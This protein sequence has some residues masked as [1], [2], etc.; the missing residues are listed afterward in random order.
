[1][2]RKREKGKK[3]LPSPPKKERKQYDDF[4]VVLRKVRYI[5]TAHVPRSMCIQLPPGGG[6][7]TKR[8]F[9]KHTC[10][11]ALTIFK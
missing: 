9:Q 7:T 6:N 4:F 3:L 11:P 5:L 2:F 10:I 1:L 8:W